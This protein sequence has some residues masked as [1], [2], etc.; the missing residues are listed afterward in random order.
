MEK[1]FKKMQRVIDRAILVANICKEI[2]K[3]IIRE[4]KK[5]GKKEE[6]FT[7]WYFPLK[8]EKRK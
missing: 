7:M 8:K 2:K 6:E 3:K 1:S 4:G 5:R